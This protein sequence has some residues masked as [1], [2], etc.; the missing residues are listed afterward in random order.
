MPDE[1]FQLKHVGPGVVSMDNSGP[2]GETG[3]TYWLSK[4]FLATNETPWLDGNYVVFGDV[5]QGMDVLKKIE[6][7]HGQSNGITKKAIVIY[8]CGVLN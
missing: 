7:K 1:N 5:I 3:F 4:I 2:T 6:E 8:D